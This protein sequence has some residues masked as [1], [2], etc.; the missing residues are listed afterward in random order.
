MEEVNN[1]LQELYQKKGEIITSIE[2]F[3]NQLQQINQEIIKELGL[4]K[5]NADKNESTG[6][7]D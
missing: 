6:N 4:Q 2:L 3:K 7:V 5:K 1:K